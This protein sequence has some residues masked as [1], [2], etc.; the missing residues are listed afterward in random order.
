MLLNSCRNLESIDISWCWEVTDAG[1]DH[2]INKCCRIVDMNICGV[3]QVL[4]NPLKEIPQRM[5]GLRRLSVTMC[6]QIPCIYNAAYDYHRLLWEEIPTV[7]NKSLIVST[8]PRVVGASLHCKQTQ[9][10]TDRAT[11]YKIRPLEV[12]LNKL[13]NLWPNKTKLFWDWW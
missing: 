7:R 9:S 12:P 13:L 3:G 1:L 6:D 10:P 5:L 8:F 4:G 11:D 2:V